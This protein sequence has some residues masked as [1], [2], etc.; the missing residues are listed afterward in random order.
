MPISIQTVLQSSLPPGESG[1]SG[2][3][4]YSG[5][6]GISGYSGTS[7][8]SGISGYSGWSGIS[9]FSGISGYSGWSGISG[10]SGING[11][12]GASGTSGWS[13]ISGYSG[14]SGISG[15]TGPTVYPG[16]GIAVSTGSAWTT[17]KT[18]PS[19]DIVG[20]TDTQT[21]TSKTITTV[22]LKETKVAMGADNI[23]LASGNYFTKTISGATSLTVSNTPASGTA[24][25]FILD[26]T[27]GGSGTITWW[28][29][30]K[31]AAGT[32]PALTSSGRDV[33]GFFTHDGG[34][35]WSGLVLG[36]DLK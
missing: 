36:K 25:S 12:N 33:L 21:L 24:A 7:G 19:G 2:I 18:S 13:G 3:S 31:W 4:G 35:T 1:F 10:Y 15:A 5:F 17:S 9:G 20:T 16:A 23:D 28:S 6:S 27:N 22:S 8:Y 11:S 30:M 14:W 29:G 26:L 34:T 32:A